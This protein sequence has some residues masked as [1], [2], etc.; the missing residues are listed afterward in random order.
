MTEPKN[1]LAL[2]ELLQRNRRWADSM[3]AKD[4]NFFKNLKRRRRPNTCGSAAPTAAPAN[5]LL[6]MAPGDV[7]VHRNIANVV[8]HSDLNCLSVLQFAVDVLK[9]KHVI[10][11]GH[12]GCKGVHA[13]MTGT[14]IGLVDNWLR[15]V[16][17]V[18]QK[19]DAIWATC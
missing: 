19:H 11:V 13:A 6:G 4:P 10:I 14:R 1:G 18:G 9:V 17:D 5:E 16:Q 12:Y 15:H 7:F 3:V 8:V 2:A